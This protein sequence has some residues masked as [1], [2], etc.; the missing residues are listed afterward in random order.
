[1]SMGIGTFLQTKTNIKRKFRWTL[2]FGPTSSGGGSFSKVIKPIMLKSAARPNLEIEEGEINFMNETDYIPTKPKWQ[3]MSVVFRDYAKIG[4]GGADECIL[5]WIQSCYAFGDPATSGQMS[6]PVGLCRRDGTLVMY[7][8]VGTPLE[9]WTMY[10][11]WITANNWGDVSYNDSDE[12]ELEATIRYQN[13][14]CVLKN[15][16]S[17]KAGYGP[18]TL[19][20]G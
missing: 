16:N 8:G 7:N 15:G 14:K 4:G 19:A 20:G 2:G 18:N 11:C 9:I 13:A 1:M 6:D 12:S 3:S 17:K 10:G 5:E